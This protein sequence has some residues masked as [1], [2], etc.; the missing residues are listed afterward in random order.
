MS[1]KYNLLSYFYF[2]FDPEIFFRDSAL[3]SRPRLRFFGAISTLSLFGENAL[4]KIASGKHVVASCH[5]AQR[6]AT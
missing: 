3:K 4:K 1:I 5:G 6:A 2:L